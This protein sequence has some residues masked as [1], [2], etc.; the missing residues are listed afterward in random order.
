MAE[1]DFGAVRAEA[2]L[3]AEGRGEG[4]QIENMEGEGSD[5]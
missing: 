1:G 2:F 4:V 3:I 5:G